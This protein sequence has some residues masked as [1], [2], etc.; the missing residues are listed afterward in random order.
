M[1]TAFPAGL[2]NFTNP[3][4]GD[5]LDSPTVPHAT[6]HANINDAVE[7]IEDTLGTNPQGDEATVKARLE[8]MTTAT[9]D[10]QAAA[11]AAQGAADDAQ[12]A[13]DN[14]QNTADDAL[15]AAGTAQDGVDALV[16]D[17]GTPTG[18]ALALTLDQ[19]A[20]T[21]ADELVAGTDPGEVDDSAPVGYVKFVVDGTDYAFPV[22]AINPVV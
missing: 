22:F 13:A 7:A 20:A 14:A 4:A 21:T 1:T 16:T 3:T 11:E 6:Q 10:A 2:D 9:E 19:I 8:A 5:S 18:S 17:L 15:S 12:T